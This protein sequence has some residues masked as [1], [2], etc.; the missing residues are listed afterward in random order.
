M[1]AASSQQQGKGRLSYTSLSGQRLKQK[2]DEMMQRGI[3]QYRFPEVPRSGVAQPSIVDYWL[4]GRILL[5]WHPEK[6]HPD[7]LPGA[8]LRCP[9]CGKPFSERFLASNGIRQWVD[10]DQSHFLMLYEYR[11]RAC[12]KP[13]HNTHHSQHTAC[14]DL[15]E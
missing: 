11:C 15:E 13:A 5:V 9:C 4:A 2:H 1:A 12:G 14:A 10:F 8:K 6:T 7:H 3:F